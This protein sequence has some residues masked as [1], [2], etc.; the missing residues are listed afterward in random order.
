MFFFSL[1]HRLTTELAVGYTLRI[2][3]IAIPACYPFMWLMGIESADLQITARLFAKKTIFNEFLAFQD[4]SI[5][6]SSR[7]A[8]LCKCREER[9]EWMSPRSEAIITYALSGFANLQCIGIMIGGLSCMV[10]SRRH[11]VTKLG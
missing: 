4:M 9:T 7:L 11:L 5:A 10:P 1:I 3:D 6:L 8:G 2:E